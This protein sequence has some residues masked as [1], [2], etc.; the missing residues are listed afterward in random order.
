[1]WYYI[2]VDIGKENDFEEKIGL[3]KVTLILLKEVL[4]EKEVLLFFPCIE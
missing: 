4:E 1:M 3:M 2:N